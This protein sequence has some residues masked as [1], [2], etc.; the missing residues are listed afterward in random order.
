MDRSTQSTKLLIIHIIWIV[1]E[2]LTDEAEAARC[3][4]M[5]ADQG[6]ADAQCSLGYCYYNGEG[7]S[8]DVKKSNSRHS[9]SKM[10]SLIILLFK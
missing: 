8:R 4:R 7:V 10:P 3:Y 1:H 2:L 9:T 6:H 5:T